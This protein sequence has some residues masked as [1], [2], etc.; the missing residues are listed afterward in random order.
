MFSR[1]DLQIES[2]KSSGPG[3][4]NVNAN[5]TAIRIK[6]IP[7]GFSIKFVNNLINNKF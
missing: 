2:M 5:P 7:T 3:G 6:H 4:A 1:E